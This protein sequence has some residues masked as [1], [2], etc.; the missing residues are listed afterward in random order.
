[1]EE[2]DE[3][4]QHPRPD[5]RQW[6]GD[7]AGVGAGREGAGEEGHDGDTSVTV[8]SLPLSSDTT[9]STGG[10]GVGEAD[11]ASGRGSLSKHQADMLD[12]FEGDMCVNNCVCVY[13]WIVRTLWIYVYVCMCVY[14]HVHICCMHAHAYHECSSI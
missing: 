11:A 13:M 7:D 14:V 4:E 3:V 5:S 10:L 8:S 6:H 2:D 12:A 9:L 1:M